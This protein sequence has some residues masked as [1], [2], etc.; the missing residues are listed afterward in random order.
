MRVRVQRTGPT[1]FHSNFLRTLVKSRL[2]LDPG[3]AML[4]VFEVVTL[5]RWPDI[6]H[7]VIDATDSW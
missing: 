4:T 1:G 3:L 7:S 2:D 6:M 5:K